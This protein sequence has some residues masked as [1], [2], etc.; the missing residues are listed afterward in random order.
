VDQ[1]LA[2]LAMDLEVEQ[3]VFVDLI[4]IE[5]IVRI[6]RKRPARST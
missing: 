4:V 6:E 1:N 5:K 3:D 2:R